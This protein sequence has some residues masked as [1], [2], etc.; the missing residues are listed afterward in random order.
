LIGRYEKLCDELTVPP[1]RKRADESSAKSGDDADAD[2][3]P[4][5]G[6]AHARPAAAASDAQQRSSMLLTPGRAAGDLRTERDLGRRKS[7]AIATQ[8]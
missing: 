8:N 7:P 4:P 1:L 6:A 5:S 2:G 3:A